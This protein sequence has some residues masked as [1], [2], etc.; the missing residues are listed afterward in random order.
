MSEYKYRQVD[1]DHPSFLFTLEDVLKEVMGC[2]V[3]YNPY[4]KTFG[5]KGSENILDFGCGGGTGSKCLLKY[6]NA[7]GHVTC[8]DTSKYWMEKTKKRLSKYPNVECKLGDIRDLPIPDYSFD[9]ITVIHVM[10]DIDRSNRQS[11]VNILSKKLN[12]EGSLFIREPTKKSHGM[13]VKEIR[14]MMTNA[15]LWEVEHEEKKSEY[16]GRFIKNQQ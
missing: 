12:K 7:K 8:I 16:K 10:H 14:T 3:F 15:D 2:L 1:F 11:T 5:L 9:V 13:A 4:I 6:L